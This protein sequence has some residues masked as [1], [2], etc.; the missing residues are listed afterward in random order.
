MWLV[1][2]VLEAG[3]GMQDCSV[4]FVRH[5]LQKAGHAYACK[6]SPGHCT[7]CVQ[8]QHASTLQASCQYLFQTL[9]PLLLGVPP[10]VVK[11]YQYTSLTSVT[12][13]VSLAAV[14]NPCF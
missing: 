6:S 10:Q 7:S 9:P 8:L 13:L 12:L 4:S 11:A 2:C 3:A 1:R 14:M 5:S